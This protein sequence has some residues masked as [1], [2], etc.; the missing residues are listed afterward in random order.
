M[1]QST[2]S[3]LGE[4]AA[5]TKSRLQASRK[6][7]ALYSRALK[8]RQKQLAA[9][10]ALAEGRSAFFVTGFPRTGNTYLTFVLAR[11]Y[12]SVDFGHHLHMPLALKT[13]LTAELACYVNLRSPAESVPSLVLHNARKSVPHFTVPALERIY[14]DAVFL[15]S[16]YSREY[17]NYYSYVLRCERRLRV[18]ASE[19][20]FDDV[21][22]VVRM[23]GRDNSLPLDRATEETCAAATTDFWGRK[24]QQAERNSLSA[25]IP[26]E[27]KRRAKLEMLQRLRSMGPFREAERLYEVLSKRRWLPQ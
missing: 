19:Q 26:T 18:L 9:L 4:L 5:Q 27:E 23:I 14:F 12:P 11:C 24:A 10:S 16:M 22:S 15:L 3:W 13:A 17:V 1:N 20:V 2:R 25:G 8:D 7:Y 6:G 21:V